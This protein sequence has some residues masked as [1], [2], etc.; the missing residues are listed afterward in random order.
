VLRAFF[1]LPESEGFALAGGAAI[2]LRGFVDRPTRDLDL[3]TPDPRPLHV[4]GVV[5]TDALRKL[6]MVVEVA[7]SSP[8]FVRLVVGQGSERIEVDLAR[9]FRWQAPGDHDGVPVIADRELAVDKALALFG[10]AEARDFIDFRRLADVFGVD[11]VLRW[12]Q[13][14]DAGFDR[15]VFAEMLGRFSQRRRVDF[16][17]GDVE[18]STL[19]EWYG[20]LAASLIAGTLDE[21]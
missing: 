15:Y 21:I 12:A 9:D 1:A 20:A 10:R 6:G 11:E 14:K 7:R 17:I 3:F 5:T 2:V 18:Y 4:V 19:A 16:P 8:T 13:E